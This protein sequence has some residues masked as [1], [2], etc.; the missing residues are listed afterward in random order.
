M[1]VGKVPR[2][3]C[4]EKVGR[5]VDPGPRDTGGEEPHG[6]LK[7]RGREG[8]KDG[9]HAED[10]REEAHGEGE[11]HDVPDLV[12]DDEVLGDA[13][14]GLLDGALARDALDDAAVVDLAGRLAPVGDAA[15][16]DVGERVPDVGIGPRLAHDQVGQVGEE[17]RG[18]EL[19]E[20]A[21]EA[22][23]PELGA[24]GK[25][26]KVEPVTPPEA[27]ACELDDEAPRVVDGDGRP[28]GEVGA[29][30]LDEE[31]PRKHHGQVDHRGEKPQ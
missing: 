29:R 19:Q 13:A 25:P 5:G 10:G 31:W 8:A 6:E 3:V 11:P 24:G 30:V 2:H 15:D 17:A 7:D 26:R 16:L 4:P 1:Q 21:H 12:Q 18:G 23:G 20:H 27:D 9:G 14:P 28:T 22:R